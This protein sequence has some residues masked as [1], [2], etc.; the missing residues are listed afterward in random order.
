MEEKYFRNMLPGKDENEETRLH[1]ILAKYKDCLSM[2]RFGFESNALPFWIS[3][4]QTTKTPSKPYQNR[5]R[6]IKKI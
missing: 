1:W 2:F 5:R 4:H 6:K 3:K